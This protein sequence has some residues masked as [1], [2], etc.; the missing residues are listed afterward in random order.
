[1]IKDLDEVNLSL[2]HL[3]E[4]QRDLGEDPYTSDVPFNIAAKKLLVF[5][6]GFLEPKA[7]EVKE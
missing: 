4:I 5:A 2:S 6:A 1:M 7:E 3:R